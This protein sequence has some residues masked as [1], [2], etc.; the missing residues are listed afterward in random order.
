MVQNSD[1]S[2]CKYVFVC[3]LPR[4]GTSL[5]GRNVARLGDCTGFKNTGVL[6]DEGQFLQDVYA[7]DHEYGGA[8]SF[9][10]DPRAHLTETSD[11]L[12]QQ[13]ALEL[14]RCWE[15]YWDAGRSIRVE[16]TPSNLLMTRFLQALFPNSYFIVM[17]RHPVAVSMAT[18]KWKD[19]VRSLDHLFEHWLHC[20]ALFE[21]DKKYLRNVY[22]L[23]Y[24][25]Y[26]GNPDKYH[27]LIAAF[28]GTYV[29]EAPTE[30]KFRY[31]VQWRN[32]TGLR[33]PE[34]AMEDVIGAHNKKYF[35]RWSKLLARSL[36][37][38]YYRYIA[39]KYEPQF[40][41]YGYSLTEGFTNNEEIRGSS[42]KVSAALGALCCVGADAGALMWR[43]STWCKEKLRVT[44]KA[45]LP[46]SAVTKIREIRQKPTVNKGN[47]GRCAETLNR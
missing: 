6:E 40:A 17:K 3:G 15:P 32:P 28:I 46:G 43:L 10:F 47:E 26:I 24:E 21:Q 35:D 42:G 31:V 7:T 41:R 36:F 4:S 11:Q 44:S 13:N 39:W 25:D 22:E 20:H 18:Q 1:K 37:K 27:H 5:L 30:D 14:R 12:T 45:V 29:P 16:K 38:R 34:S 23:S 8:G 2:N 19:S 9:G 33:V